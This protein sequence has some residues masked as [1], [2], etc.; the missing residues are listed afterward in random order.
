[1][2][3][4]TC[5]NRPATGR[6]SPRLS[7]CTQ[8]ACSRGRWRTVLHWLEGMPE[9][10]LRDD[11]WLLYWKRGMARLGTDGPGGRAVLESA[12]QAFTATG[13]LRGE[14]LACAA[15]IDSYFQEWN[16]VAALDR[17]ID[18]M[19]RLLARDALAEDALRRRALSSMVMALLYRRPAHPNLPEYVKEIEEQLPRIDDVND[20][21]CTA[22]YLLDYFSL[23]GDFNRAP[24]V[25]ALTE[26][27]AHSR[28]TLPINAFLWWQRRG[29]YGYCAGDF[30]QA[31]TGLATALCIA[32][33]NGMVDAEFVALLL[34]GMLMACVGR[35]DEAAGLLQQMRAKLNP[36][37]HMHAQGCHYLD[38]WLAILRQDV[39]Q[40]A[41]PGRRFRRHR[42]SACQRMPLIIIR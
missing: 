26:P 10:V 3:L 11:P 31:H 32:R 27:D 17:W 7:R 18:Q 19:E 13:D 12:F 41:G 37:R 34:S 30:Q 6:A 38:L 40:R 35:T 2:R 22:A 15:I 36:K 21:L 25:V 8:G 14:A 24:T 16:T 1:M 29:M 20:R 4:P 28:D 39:A 42:P 23:S 9:Q 33:E 5:C